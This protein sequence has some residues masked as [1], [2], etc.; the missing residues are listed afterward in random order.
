MIY[1][2]LIEAIIYFGKV[3]TLDKLASAGSRL[4]ELSFMD[5]GDIIIIIVLILLIVM[6]GYFSSTE[7]AYTSFNKIRMKHMAG[8]GN[9]RAQLVLSL[10]SN[11]DRLLS[12]ILIGN[13]IVNIVAASLATVLFTR[14]LGGDLGLTVSTVIMTVLVLIFGEISPK[15]LAKEAPERFVMFSAPLL[16]VFTLLLAP[17]N[18]LFMR[19][20]GLLRL[21]FKFKEDT[22]ITEEELLT[23]VEEAESGGGIDQHESEL[24]RNAIEFNDLDAGD[25]LTPRVNMVAVDLLSDGKKEIENLFLE[26]GY[27]RLPVYEETLDN[28]QGIINEKDF[29]NKVLYTEERTESIVGP[30]L[31]IAPT[32]NIAKLLR[33]LQQSKTH[34]AVVTDEYGGTM[35]IVTLEDILEQLVG[36]IWDEHDKIIE[37]VTP[38]GPEE[39]RVVCSANLE[40]VFQLF[41][42]TPD[43]ELD[44]S[45]V[46]GWVLETMGKIPE[47]GECFTAD[48]LW[49]QVTRADDRRVIEIILKRCPNVDEPEEGQQS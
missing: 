28:I 15:S 17:L 3:F 26:S 24:I 20:K 48:Q 7:T 44:V 27:S 31:F 40:K 36:D 45:T 42:M 34:M 41:D 32:T 11:F 21:V 2:D 14:W 19:W 38:V 18:W 46:G 5:S 22:G 13:N 8:E 49:A 6:S 30:A 43:E 1:N 10:S 25:I 35:G 37:E 33:R 9:K 23:I 39:Y 16:R 29:H 4:E 12:T 47:E